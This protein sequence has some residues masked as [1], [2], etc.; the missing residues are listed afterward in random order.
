MIFSNI[1]QQVKK[2]EK[3]FNCYFLKIKALKILRM[4]RNSRLEQG[5]IIDLFIR[6]SLLIFTKW[7][8]EELVS[9]QK[10]IENFKNGNLENNKKM[11][12]F[13]LENK[14]ED[15]KREIES[16]NFIYIFVL[17]ILIILSFFFFY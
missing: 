12:D 2:I 8:F 6:R 16:K 9:F 11:N 7:N 17:Y 15:L 10:K 4:L 5:N 13:A 14:I 3:Y 1:Y